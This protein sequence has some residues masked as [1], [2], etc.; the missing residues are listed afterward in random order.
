MTDAE[1]GGADDEPGDR[2]PVRGR[3]RRAPAAI[4][5]TTPMT[6]ATRSSAGGTPWRS[7]SFAAASRSM[8]VMAATRAVR[9]S[10]SATWPRHPGLAAHDRRRQR[11]AGGDGDARPTPTS[12]TGS[13]SSTKSPM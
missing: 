3:R 7:A 10:A 9:A 1:E 13:G 6:G 5:P 4:R 11:H 12:R 2:E 8:P